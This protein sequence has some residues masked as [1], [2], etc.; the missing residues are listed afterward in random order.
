MISLEIH[1]SDRVTFRR[2][3]RK[4]NWQSRLRENL[5]STI[6]S[7]GPLWFG[8]GFHFALEDFHGHNK[9]GDPR[10]A[11]DAY[12]GAFP[13]S[14]LPNDVDELVKLGNEML[15]YYVDL[16]IPK[17]GL[18]QTLW[19]G[20]A[21]QVEVSIEIP[22]EEL[23]QEYTEHRGLWGW[24]DDL[25][26]RYDAEPSTLKIVVHQTFDRVVRDEDGRIF[27]IDYKTAKQFSPL[28]DLDKN[29]QAGQYFW[30]MRQFYGDAAEGIIWQQHLKTAPQSPKPLKVGGF[31]LNKDQH[32]TYTLYRRALIDRFGK[33]PR[34]YVEILNHLALQETEEGDRYIR[35]DI[36][37]RNTAHGRAEQEKIL[38]EVSEM[39]N[40]DL[41]LY[42]NPTRDCNWDC[43]FKD[44]CSAMD[45][46]SDYQYMLES[47]FVQ[48]QGYQD[49]WRDRIQW[50][51]AERATI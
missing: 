40:P 4:W 32:T 46:G 37:R 49:D 39:L 36:L 41:P 17:Y 51:D 5:V 18:M 15:T 23:L 2:C 22:I 19:I 8:S 16:W 26:R 7:R 27:G 10:R 29:P 12:V 11:F 38:A 47:E 43:P 35:R 20:D 13:N 50:P 34:G 45:D 6:E 25:Y 31:S 44:A 48:W 1:N 42:P 24:W 3:R 21:P 14:A 28:G 33:V 30:A 9:F